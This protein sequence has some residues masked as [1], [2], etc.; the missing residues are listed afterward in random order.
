[1]GDTT[2]GV[3]DPQLVQGW[4]SGGE[5]HPRC[6]KS[7]W[8]LCMAGGHSEHTQLSGQSS[9]SH[10]GGATAD[11]IDARTA[12]V[13]DATLALLLPTEFF[14]LRTSQSV[15]VRPSST[16]LSTLSRKRRPFHFCD[17]FVVRCY[18]ILLDFGRNIPVPIGNLKQTHVYSPPRAVVL[19][20]HTVHC[21]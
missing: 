3:Q 21:T 15:A 5:Y 1:M 14:K 11:E 7:V 16:V 18:Q 20:V 2:Q 9:R 6:H 13:E 19:Y 8:L 10:G 4:R 17:I 12:A